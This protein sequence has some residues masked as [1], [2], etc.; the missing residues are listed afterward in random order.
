[1]AHFTKDSLA[2]FFVCNENIVKRQS[3]LNSFIKTVAEVINVK[4]F[5][6]DIGDCEV[7]HRAHTESK[8][9]TTHC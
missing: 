8:N 7:R 3:D 9:T 5:I 2:Q 1:M 4:Y 6:F